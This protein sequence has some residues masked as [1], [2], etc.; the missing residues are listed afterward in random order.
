M[1]LLRWITGLLLVTLLGC[2]QAPERAL[3]VATSLW[4]GYEPL[5]LADAIDAYEQNIEMIQLAS[6]RE[7]TRALRNGTV[8]VVATTLDEALQ[9]KSQGEDLVLLIV[10]NFSAGADVIMARPPVS[11]LAAIQGLRVGVDNSGVGAVMLSAA[12]HHAN[13]NSTDIRLVNLPVYHH[14]K[15]YNEGT[16]DVVVTCEPHATHLRAA[17][18]NLLF[19][20]SAMSDLIMDVLIVRRN[21]FK[22]RQDALQDLI[23][24]YYRARDYMANQTAESSGLISRRLDISPQELQK[25]W[26]SLRLPSLQDNI[27]WLSGSPSAFD[28]ARERLEQLMVERELLEPRPGGRLRGRPDWLRQVAQ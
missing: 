1:G 2:V 13:L 5:Y 9:L 25:T 27:R 19:D 6:T 23:R 12:L 26:T 20:S 28:D 16:I 21:V 10:L 3:K 18:A 8:D 15:A 14:V 24:G 11:S 17:G 4:P 7:V 22:R